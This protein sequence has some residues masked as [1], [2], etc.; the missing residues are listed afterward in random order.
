MPEAERR[1]RA[2]RMRERVLAWTARDWLRAQL[3]DLEEAAPARSIAA[4]S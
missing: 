1:S 3:A 4:A 2:A